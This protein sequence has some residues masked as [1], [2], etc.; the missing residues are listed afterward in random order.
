MPDTQT[1]TLIS[2]ELVLAIFG[3]L[4]LL[5]DLI[6][7]EKSAGFVPWL[8]ILGFVL[9]LVATSYI[10]G[11]N[12]SLFFGMY[13]IDLFALFFKILACLAGIIITLV[14][15]DY[16]RKRTPYK[17]EFFGLFTFSVLAMMMVASSASLLMVYLAIEFLSY[18]SYLLTGF[19]RE[20]KKSNEAAI[21]Y[22]LYGAI[23]SEVML[24]GFSLLFGATGSLNLTDI[25]KAFAASVDPSIKLLAVISTALVLA[26][27]GFK[28]SLVPFHQ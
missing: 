9:A 24:Y 15:I 16:L 20:D 28:I 8:T 17:G 3:L 14:S 7:R 18:T 10:W 4:I 26:G 12:I 27:L 6:W 25:A 21:K 2:P 19:L 5:V 1:L 23:T 22:F 11:S 13:S